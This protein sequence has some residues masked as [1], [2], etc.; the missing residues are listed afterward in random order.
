MPPPTALPILS[1]LWP[2]LVSFGLLAV[3]LSACGEAATPTPEVTKSP[4]VGATSTAQPKSTPT[5]KPAT[6]VS[7][8]TASAAETPRPAEPTKP[9]SGANL[10]SLRKVDWKAVLAKDPDIER[11][12]IPSTALGD[13]WVKHKTA[14]AEGYPLLENVLYGDLRGD[15]NE[16]AV[17]TLESGGTAGTIGF[18]VY[19]P[20]ASGPRIAAAKTGQKLDAQIQEGQ[21]VVQESIYA[22]WE[23]NCCPSSFQI[24]RY[25]LQGETLASVGTERQP[26]PEAKVQTVEYYY[27][28]LNQKEYAQAY[29]FLSPAVQAANPYSQWVAGYASTEN[30]D[31][32]VEQGPD[33]SVA[34][35]LTATE[36][37]AEGRTQLRH[38]EG[39]W[40]LAFSEQRNQWLLDRAQIAEVP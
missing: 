26:Q 29:T 14:G 40:F 25:R 28:L 37:A 5:R 10:G 17:I 21:L 11:Q 18:L 16:E 35:T 22:G 12:S 9:P 39:R 15:G 3:I 2:W 8:E 36:R 27:G 30:T 4:R 32:I 1:R 19:E 31:A 33:D 34:V 6:P 20:T 24:T 38:F 7:K 13:L 23:P